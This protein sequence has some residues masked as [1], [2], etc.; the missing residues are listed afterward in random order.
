MTTFRRHVNDLKFEIKRNDIICFTVEDLIGA[1]RMIIS[2]S[3]FKNHIMS[4]FSV[5]LKPPFRLL[6][7]LLRGIAKSADRFI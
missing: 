2:F 3:N 1:N 6:Y 7:W 5:L 4:K